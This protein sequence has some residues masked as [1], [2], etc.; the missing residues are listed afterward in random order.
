MRWMFLLRRALLIDDSPLDNLEARQCLRV[1]VE[2]DRV[3]LVQ[4]IFDWAQSLFLTPSR[5]TNAAAR[6]CCSG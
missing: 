6:V 3:E 4:A 5:P 1:A 2:V